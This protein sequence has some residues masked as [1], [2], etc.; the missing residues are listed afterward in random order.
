[1]SL[2]NLENKQTIVLHN[3]KINNKTYDLVISPQN[4]T[5]GYTRTKH[6]TIKRKILK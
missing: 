5:I 1:M 3:C 4:Q 6:Q 2:N